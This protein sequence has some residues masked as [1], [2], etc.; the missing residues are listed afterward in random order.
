MV[1]SKNRSWLLYVL[2]GTAWLLIS[3]VATP[4]L[5]CAL[6]PTAPTGL[7]LLWRAM[8]VLFSWFWLCSTHHIISDRWSLGVF[9]HELAAL[10]E[11]RLESKPSPLPELT[12][13]YAD[14]AAWQRKFLSSGVME[15]QLAYWRRQLDGA[16]PC[17][18]RPG[19]RRAGRARARG[20]RHGR[21]RRPSRRVP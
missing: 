20:G 8:I 10:Y 6:A 2:M 19:R 17:R 1:K 12:I 5:L 16:A 7:R 14:Y 18:G 21:L 11:A 3:A 13:Q 9:S 15:E 4:R